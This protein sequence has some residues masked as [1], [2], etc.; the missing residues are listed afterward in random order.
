LNLVNTTKN[1]LDTDTTQRLKLQT[2][3]ETVRLRFNPK[4]WRQ[5]QMPLA[6]ILRLLHVSTALHLTHSR[7]SFGSCYL[8]FAPLP[9]E[10]M[11]VGTWGAGEAKPP[12]ILQ[13]LAKKGCF[14]SFEGEK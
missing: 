13:F 2:S 3:N 10:S 6:N 4:I 11:G 9:V 7:K 14:L 1:L 5:Q 12:W 8:K